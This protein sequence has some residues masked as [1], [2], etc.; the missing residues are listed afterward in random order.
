MTQFTH[1]FVM[2]F[3]RVLAFLVLF[4]V[5]FQLFGQADEELY[6]FQTR[7]H[8]VSPDELNRLHESGLGFIPTPPPGGKVRRIAEFEPMEGVIVGYSGSF[9][10]PFTLIA[11]MAQVA[12]VY[13]IVANASQENTVRNQYIANGVDINNCVFVR[14]PLNSYWARD[15]SPW[16]IADSA[17]RMAI[18]DFPYNRP[19]PNDNAVPALFAN[20]LGMPMYGMNVLH[21]GGNFMCDGL[22]RAAS[23]KLVLN[24]NTN[25]SITQ[26]NDYMRDYMGIDEYYTFDDPMDDYI[27]HIDCWGKFLAPDKVLLTQVPSNDPRYPDFEAI[28][29]FFAAEISS[30]GT[31]YRVFRVYSPNGQPYT[32]SLILNHKVFVPVVTTFGSPWNDS[33]IAVYQRAM[34]GY[35]IAGIFALAN[36]PWASTDALHCRVHEMPDRGML[37]IRHIPKHGNTI[38]QNNYEVRAEVIPFSD[39]TLVQD[40]LF[41]SYRYETGQWKT[42]P[43]NQDTGFVW[44]GSIPDSTFG[45][46]IS[47]VVHAA[48][49]S[50]RR[51]THPYIGKADPHRFSIIS[52]I[53]IQDY[54]RN[55]RDILI[56]PNPCDNRLFAAVPGTGQAV[57][58]IY[59]VAGVM[60]HQE[61]FADARQLFRQGIDMSRV[62]NGVY[63]AEIVTGTNRY[64]KKVMVVRH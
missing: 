37:Y 60:V 5:T 6:R 36:R 49:N 52:N 10:I 24:E 40:S 45:I 29:A 59:S 54:G 39:S 50:G 23:T 15:Y 32:N 58:R 64:V 21:T 31:P 13:T 61:E 22:G 9:G 38:Q 55:K 51:E 20:E 14:G 35:D 7:T 41:I 2:C 17:N 11:Q 3:R 33:A 53:G 27:D 48:D 16:F 25:L 46:D 8:M 44:V 30:Y 47:Y 26:I 12:T 34:P 62:N 63:M 1:V 56:Y 28:A 19:R 18:I 43:M 4:P 57:V 42:T